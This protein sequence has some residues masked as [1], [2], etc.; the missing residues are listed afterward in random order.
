M[1]WPLEQEAAEAAENKT[2]DRTPGGH[3]PALVN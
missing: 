2:Q 3:E 1:R